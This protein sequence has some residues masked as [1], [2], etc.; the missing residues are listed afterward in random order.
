MLYGDVTLKILLKEKL[1]AKLSK[2]SF[3]TR[4][5]DH[6]WHIITGKRVAMDKNKVLAVKEWPTP[7]NLKQLRGFLGLT[8]HYRRLINGYAA[9]ASSLTDL[10]KND[11]FK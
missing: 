9:L 11:A 10:L 1:Y 3:G 7:T 8:C 2:C 5:V 4:E 6:L